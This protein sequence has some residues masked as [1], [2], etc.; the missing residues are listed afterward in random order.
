M[1]EKDVNKKSKK[2][3][4]IAIIVIVAILA[5]GVVGYF[6]YQGQQV[7]LLTAEIQKAVAIAPTNADGSI[8]EN[9]VIDMEIKTKGDYAI[10]EETLKTYLNETLTLAK[11][12]GNV[13]D[14]KAI[15]NVVSIE[16]I[17]KDGPDFV[18]TKAKLAEMK[19]NGEEYIDKFIALCNE[20]NLLAAIDEKPVNDYY[21]EL[22]K[23]LATDENAGEELAKTV[24]E[25]KGAKTTITESFDYLNNIVEFLSKNKVSWTVQGDQIVF[26]SQA[27]LNEYNKL[28]SEVPGE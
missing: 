2:G 15:E 8:N 17:K 14:Q 22:Y 6:A 5:I 24:E 9:A 23:Q 26:F 10:V 25:L 19:K 20:E 4:I 7:A 18:E 11:N 28:V 27:K 3:L 16:N 1:G 12:A 21:K 13:F